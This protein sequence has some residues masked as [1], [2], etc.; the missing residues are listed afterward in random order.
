MKTFTFLFGYD[1]MTVLLKIN[2]KMLMKLLSSMSLCSYIEASVCVVNK[3]AFLRHSFS[4]NTQNLQ[5]SYLVFLW[6]SIHSH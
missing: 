3:T 4:R 5:D 1:M 2:G 6:L